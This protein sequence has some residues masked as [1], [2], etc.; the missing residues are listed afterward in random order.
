LNQW[1][2]QRSNRSLLL[3]LQRIAHSLKGGAKMVKLE[4]VADIAYELENAFEQF[5]QHNFNSNV[6]DGL[7]ESAF[8]WLDAAIFKQSYDNFD[9]LKL[10]LNRMNMLMFLLSFQKNYLEQFDF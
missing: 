6:Y 2:D 3:Q 4:G 7:L 1:F 5:G 10:N 8:H 9:G